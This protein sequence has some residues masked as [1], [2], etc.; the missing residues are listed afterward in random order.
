[1]RSAVLTTSTIESYS[2]CGPL[3]AASTVIKPDI[4]GVDNVRLSTFGNTAAEGT[5]IATP[6]VAGLAALVKQ[7]NPGFTPAQIATYLKDNALRR[8]QLAPNNPWGYGL[9]FLPHVGPVITGNPQLS[10]TLT[11]NT[12]AVADID[13]VP[14][15]PTFTYQWIRVSSGGT[16][17][18]ISGA[19]IATYTPVQ[20]DV[21]STLKVKVSFTDSGP[22]AEEQ[23]SRASLKVVPALNT[24]ATGKP[25]IAGTLPLR[26]T[27]T[28]MASTSPIGD[29][30]GITGVT[31]EYQWVQVDGGTDIDI[32]GATES[33]YVLQPADEGK[34]VKVKVSFTDDNR[35]AESVVSDESAVVGS[36]PN[37][38]PMFSEAMPSRWVRENTRANRNIGLA[39]TATDLE[40]DPFTYSI[41]GGSDLFDIVTT[42]DTGQLQTKGALD[43]EAASSHTIVVQVTDNKDIEGMAD[44]VIDATITVTIAVINEDDPPIISGD[45][46]RSIEEGGAVLLGIYTATDQ[47]GDFIAWQPLDGGDR[48]KFELNRWRGGRRLSFKEEPDFEDADRGGDNEYRVTLGVSAGGHTT[49]FD[50]VVTV[51]N[52]EEPGM[53]ALPATRP[54]AEADYTATLSDPD[55]VVST[56][57]TWERSMSRGGTWEPVTGAILDSTETSV[58]T[59]VTDDVGHYLRATAAYT[60]AL[61]PPD[62]SLVAL[63]TNSVRAASL[64]NT[65]PAFAETNPTRSVAE[66]ARANAPVG[67]RV[68]AT[69]PDG[70]T[71]RY[72]FDPDDPGDSDLF[73]IDASSGQ[74]QVKTQGALDYE[75]QPMPTIKVKASDNSNAFATVLVTIDVTD[76]NEPPHAVA[77]PDATTFEDTEVIIYVLDNDSDPEDE[78]SAL[79]V[80]WPRGPSGGRSW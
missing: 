44:M 28:V 13:G 70:N 33:S 7:R 78:R 49:T 45:A 21:G 18:N 39:I 55:G 36:A 32:P 15:S 72:E 67:D 19:T 4:V 17:A 25:T 63:S 42:N 26:V 40:N 16:E 5:S 51:T 29:A 10:V 1:M 27:Q 8:G 75:T 79:T 57:W 12:D 61:S 76:V 71:V 22:H 47:D 54:Q 77:D 41:K 66:N 34:T 30:D 80:R 31:F 53:L 58:Y 37:R 73:T 46:A 3:P 23:T 60:D 43:Y 6:H 35:N 59:P 14:A 64:A 24:P 2:A 65:P 38:A 52:K 69:D 62:K 50:V 9:A 11:A 20:A 48:D 68:T 56:T 74:I